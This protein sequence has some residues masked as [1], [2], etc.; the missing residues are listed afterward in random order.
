M[1]GEW[2]GSPLQ[3]T[4]L[5]LFCERYLFPRNHR[6][7]P[8]FVE[9]FFV[10]KY[11][12]QQFLYKQHIRFFSLRKSSTHLSR[13]LF[14]PPTLA[15]HPKK[16]PFLKTRQRS[17]QDNTVSTLGVSQCYIRSSFEKSP[18]HMRYWFMLWTFCQ[19]QKQQQQ[20]QQWQ[21]NRRWINF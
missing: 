18:L 11:F 1:S 2:L 17:R 4:P 9:Y 12:R 3:F 6:L 19:I 16:R 21:R 13:R 8:Q 5:P 14:S 7:K 10:S 15:V 20:Q